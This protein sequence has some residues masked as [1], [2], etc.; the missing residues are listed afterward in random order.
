MSC[1]RRRESTATIVRKLCS[2]IARGAEGLA[3]H[4]KHDSAA[5]A[6]TIGMR[7]VAS[8]AFHLSPGLFETIERFSRGVELLLRRE[9]FGADFFFQF[10]H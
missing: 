3:R 4:R 2:T 1:R 6:A 9:R 7:L 10:Q 5:I 8:V